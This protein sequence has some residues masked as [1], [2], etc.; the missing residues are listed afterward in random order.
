MRR[1]GAR[2]KV[3]GKSLIKDAF[4]GNE[5]IVSSQVAA[6]ELPVRTTGLSDSEQTRALENYK[7]KQ[8]RRGWS[9]DDDEK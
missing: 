3:D 7:R 1:H 6:R 2:E 8:Q 4:L 9:G 5:R